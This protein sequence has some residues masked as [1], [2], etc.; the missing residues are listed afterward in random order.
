MLS[1]G[2]RERWIWLVLIGSLAFNAGVGATFGV[3]SYRRSGD[4]QRRDGRGRRDHSTR[5]MEQLNLTAEQTERV[6]ASRARMKEIIDP[7]K[8]QL[9]REGEALADLM[10][11]SETDLEAIDRQLNQL[12]VGR[13]DMLHAI[14]E[15]FLEVKAV[16]APEQQEEFAKV[17]RK[18]LSYGGSG[19]MH[20][21]DHRGSESRGPG[22][23]DSG[24][25]E[26]TGG[27]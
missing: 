2:R 8:A 5:L 14:V 21:G 19:R 26:K 12:A 11:A 18:V 15:H 16:L 17:I 20:K 24:A 4:D 27:C 13:K 22:P 7:A 6:E 23:D 3:K 9:K 1:M 25:S 10:A